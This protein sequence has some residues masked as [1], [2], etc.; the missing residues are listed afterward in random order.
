MR[1]IERDTNGDVV[2]TFARPQY[3]GQ[4]SVPATDPDVLIF[5]SKRLAYHDVEEKIEAEIK[6]NARVTAIQNLKDRGEL[7][8]NYIDIKEITRS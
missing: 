6:A 3:E 7:D 5:E 2:G 8:I 1:F 4:E